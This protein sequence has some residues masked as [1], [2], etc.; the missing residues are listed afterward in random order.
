MVT[1][2]RC[3]GCGKRISTGYSLD[4]KGKLYIPM[5]NPFCTR[6]C[7]MKSVREQIL[8]FDLRDE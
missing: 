3:Q 7:L 6:K 8:E 1:I 4:G 5:F 2:V